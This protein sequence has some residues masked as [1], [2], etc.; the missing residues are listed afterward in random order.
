MSNQLSGQPGASP[1]FYGRRVR[2]GNSARYP[3]YA[4]QFKAWL[5][6]RATALSSTSATIFAKLKK[7]KAV[8]IQ[9]ATNISQLP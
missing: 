8:T 3:R 6:A 5:A 9:A 2:H 4:L 1:R 7:Y